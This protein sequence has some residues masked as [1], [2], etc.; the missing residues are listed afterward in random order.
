PIESLLPVY[1]AL[2]H[3]AIGRAGHDPEYRGR[4]FPRWSADC[5]PGNTVF[6]SERP[7]RAGPAVAGCARCSW[8]PASARLDPAVSEPPD[9]LGVALAA[10]SLSEPE[11]APAPEIRPDPGLPPSAEP[12]DAEDVERGFRFDHLMMMQL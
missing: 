5:Q 8:R 4:I 6:S 11:S 1:S 10:P 7:P 9:S 12:A 2:R 3:R